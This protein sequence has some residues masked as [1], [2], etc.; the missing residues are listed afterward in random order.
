MFKIIKHLRT[1]YDFAVRSVN[2]KVLLDL[3]YDNQE[4]IEM[5]K[6]KLMIEERDVLKEKLVMLNN[7]TE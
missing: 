3:K 5:Y 6:K 2:Y 7:N 1:I 4:L